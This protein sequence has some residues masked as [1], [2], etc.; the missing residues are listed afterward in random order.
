MGAQLRH[1]VPCIE[2]NISSRGLYCSIVKLLI[3]TGYPIE[4]GCHQA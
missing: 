2:Q 1:L 3:E 4:A